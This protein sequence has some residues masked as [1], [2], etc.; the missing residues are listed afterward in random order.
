M[1]I[2]G[3]N[4]SHEATEL[5]LFIENDADL[6]RQQMQPIQKNLV[7]KLARGIYSK[8]KAEKAW[9]YLAE[10]GAK[11]YVKEFGSGGEGEWHRMFPVSVRKEVAHILNESFLVE[12][13][14]GNYNRY[15]P[16][17]YANW[18]P[19]EGAVGGKKR[20]ALGKDEKLLA[21]MRGLGVKWK[22]GRAI[23]TYTAKM[24]VAQK[25]KADKL[26]DKMS[27]GFVDKM[28]EARKSARLRKLEAEVRDL[29]N[30]AHQ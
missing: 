12:A 3:D 21:G 30:K 1:S 15:L 28:G 5:T 10:S 4:V 22:Q 24:T 19:S 2:Y 8:A 27:E 16:K 11:K 26:Y 23:P 6:Y 20:H 17:K 13:L 9:M 14:L 25:A 29:L 18:K 7:T